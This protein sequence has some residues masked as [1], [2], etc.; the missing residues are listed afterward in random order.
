MSPAADLILHNAKV[1]TVNPE[2]PEA[3]LVAIRR[4]KILAATRNDDIDTFK[5]S[6]TKVIDC[7]G[8]TVVPG[9]NDAH[10]H[11]FA[12]AALPFC[13][14]CTPARVRSIAQLKDT[15]RERAQQID[16]GVWIR[17]LGYNDYYL[18]EQRHPTRWDLDEVAPHHPVRL[19]H[20]S[21]HACVLNSLGMQL[22]G[23]SAETPE[24]PGGY[25]ERDLNTGEP[26]GVLFGMGDHV[27][28]VAPILAPGELEE[29]MRIANEEYLSHGITSLQDAN[30]TDS[31]KRWQAFQL[32]RNKNILQ[33]RVSMMIGTD[34]IE[35]F[36]EG[37]M[38]TGTGDQHLK[39]GAVKMVLSETTGTLNPP[40][41]IL[42]EQVLN[43]HESGFQV[44][45]HCIGES[46]VEAAITALE[47]AIEKV[48]KQ[49]H[50]HRLEHCS[51]CPRR[52][53]QRV[54]SVG[55]M[56]TTQPSFIYYS[57]ERYLGTML[58]KELIWLYPVGSWLRSGV[59]AAA[60]SD[61]PIVPLDPLVGVYAAITR[62]AQSGQS[63][64]SKE[65]VSPS[66]ALR[67][68]TFDAAYSSF[69]EGAK[70]SISPGKL[71]DLAILTDNP[72]EVPPE[73][74]LGIETVMTI[75]G[76][77]VVWEKD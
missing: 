74:I 51:I 12:L 70:G 34:A 24:P 18:A 10:C 11:P 63:L 39:V 30:W 19:I 62:T 3:R 21:G 33:S 37:E 6:R 50:R 17:A 71:A 48:P 65:S 41:D 31:V 53:L 45:L 23:I 4:G 72:L 5:G 26:N 43:A 57:G 42:N 56:V 64:P 68:Y 55:A 20:R 2:Q 58:E 16:R 27:A 52:L 35:E 47:Y 7:E 67:M 76:G 29:G 49:N 40:Q 77:K 14:D 22:A 54:K 32:L 44:A 38:V 59:R 15:I 9:F 66:D 25:M 69:E 75:I 28:K 46:A 36:L 61:S 1:V 13:I 60:S 8:R 73:E